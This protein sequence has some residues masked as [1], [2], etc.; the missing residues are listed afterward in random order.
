MIS[1]SFIKRHL[2]R[3]TGSR[4]AASMA[5][6]PLSGQGRDHH[7]AVWRCEALIRRP[8]SASGNDGH[9]LAWPSITSGDFIVQQA[10]RGERPRNQ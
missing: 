5:K 1:S 4:F 7:A 9:Q 6:G 8:H 2:S 10:A 3:A